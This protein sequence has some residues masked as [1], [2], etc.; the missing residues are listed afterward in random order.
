[1]SVHCLDNRD[2]LV[3]VSF[4]DY[5]SCLLDRHAVPDDDVRL[6]HILMCRSICFPT[7]LVANPSLAS[8]TREEKRRQRDRCKGED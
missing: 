7:T 8:L 1:M 5:I 2:R 4:I 3:K 6:F